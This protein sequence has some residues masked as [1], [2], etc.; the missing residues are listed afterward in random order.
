MHIKRSIQTTVPAC[1]LFAAGA[2]Q[3]GVL[4]QPADIE[5]SDTPVADARAGQGKPLGLLY[6]TFTA[7]GEYSFDADFKGVSGDLSIYRLKGGIEV[8]LP[9]GERGRLAIGISDEYSKYDLGGNAFGGS[10][11]FKP[12][13]ETVSARYSRPF[14]EGWSMMVLAD[15]TLAGEWDAEFSDKATYGAGVLFNYKVNEELTLGVGAGVHTRVEDD[16]QA[17]PLLSLNWQIDER[18]SLALGRGATLSYAFDEDREWVLDL[19]ATYEN[20]RFR[21]DDGH[22]GRL[23]DGVIED[24]RIPLTVGLTYKPNPGVKARVYAGAVVWQELTAETESGNRISDLESDPTAMIGASL[25][26]SF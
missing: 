24:E 14:G 4:S 3:A 25:T 8:G 26:L 11:D 16:L 10:D 1:L 13:I 9:A 21:L 7:T 22:A 6:S 18:W 5:T 12:H 19:G 15:L 23:R 2:V 17:M 20:R